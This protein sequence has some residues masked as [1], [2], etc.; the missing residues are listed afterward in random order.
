MTFPEDDHDI[1]MIIELLIYS[2][3]NV[4]DDIEPLELSNHGAL[5]DAIIKICWG[6]HEKDSKGIKFDNFFTQILKHSDKLGIMSFPDTKEELREFSDVFYFCLG[7]IGIKGIFDLVESSLSRC[8]IDY[9]NGEF[10]F[11]VKINR[12]ISNLSN[13]IFDAAMNKI[14]RDTEHSYQ[15]NINNNSELNNINNELNT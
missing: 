15:T 14:N 6:L 10:D 13:S 12:T 2:I 5:I 8:L 9:T 1:F 4:G 7:K 3:E 11:K